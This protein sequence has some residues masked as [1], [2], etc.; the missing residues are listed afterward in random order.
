MIAKSKVEII[1]ARF[2]TNIKFQVFFISGYFDVV[3]ELYSKEISFIFLRS[4]N[5]KKFEI[6]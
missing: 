1:K 3:K 6:T 2:I 4:R 5:N